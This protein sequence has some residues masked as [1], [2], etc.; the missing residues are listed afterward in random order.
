MKDIIAK[1]KLVSTSSISDALDYFKIDGAIKGVKPLFSEMRLI[2]FAFTVEYELESSET[3]SVTTNY[4][5]QLSENDIV[6]IDNAGRN[7]CTVWGEM[8]TCAA[9][10]SRAG[11]VVIH[12]CCRD[13]REIIELKFPVFSCATHMQTS[14]KRVKVKAIQQP[15]TI[16]NKTICPGDLVCADN[17]GVIVVPHRYIE[18]VAKLALALDRNDKRILTAM[19]MGLSLSEAKKKFQYD[20]FAQVFMEN[21]V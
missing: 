3:N 2:G 17:D 9:M 14:K 1:L 7:F 16:D 13:S 11:G 19:K 4:P 10:N 15:I 12:G 8:L 18:G 21:Q 6:V 20:V 5:E